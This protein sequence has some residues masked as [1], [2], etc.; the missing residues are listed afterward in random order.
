MTSS[1][2]RGKAAAVQIR[3]PS[4]CDLCSAN[5]KNPT[6][7]RG[8][9]ERRPIVVI[10]TAG[11]PAEGPLTLGVARWRAVAK[12]FGPEE[13]AAAPAHFGCRSAALCLCVLNPPPP[14]IFGRS[15]RLPAFTQRAAKTV[16]V[17]EPFFP[18]AVSENSC[19]A[20]P[21]NPRFLRG[22]LGVTA[23]K[24]LRLYLCPSV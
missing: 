15:S 14:P 12:C 2:R 22:F 4:L 17:S 18:S 9:F 1:R 10:P 16:R 19:S 8:S 23:P 24:R 20:N 21:K 3:E 6:V 5:Q 13:G 7:L 11:G